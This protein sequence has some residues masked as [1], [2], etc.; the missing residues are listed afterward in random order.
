LEEE[1]TS[2][3]RERKELQRKYSHGSHRVDIAS[4]IITQRD[5]QVEELKRKL[6]DL[7]SQL[8]E[9][10]SA[11]E[12]LEKKLSYKTKE[13]NEM[14]AELRRVMI[15]RDDYL[16]ENKQHRGSEVDSKWDRE[17]KSLKR[18]LSELDKENEK[19][20]KQVQKQDELL[21]EN[22]AKSR[23]I[24]SL[25]EINS[26]YENKIVSLEKR[27]VH[28]EQNARQTEM[29]IHQIESSY[30]R[31]NKEEVAKLQGAIEDMRRQT[32]DLELIR[33]REVFERRSSW[34]SGTAI[35]RR[36]R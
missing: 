8:E 18:E 4:D 15:E 30:S 17:I 26:E 29:D 23:D 12:K 25:R 31:K 21:A 7:L 35:W 16:V 10:D 19:L 20:Y 5:Q 27:V 3:A 34:R 13:N 9:C 36:S 24:K 22:E 1:L 14:E 11:N 6:K 32:H 2:L 33:V 28:A